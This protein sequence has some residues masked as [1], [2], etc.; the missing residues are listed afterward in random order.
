MRFVSYMWTIQ[1]RNPVQPLGTGA[2]HLNISACKMF[3]CYEQRTITLW[4]TR[5]DVR[6]SVHH[7]TI[8][9]NQPTRCDSFT[10]ILLDVCV[11]LNM[12]WAPPCP[13]SGAYTC[14]R[15]LCNYRQRVVVGVLL[16]VVSRV[17]RQITTNSAPTATLQVKPEAPSAVVRC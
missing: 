17:I 12:F 10:S 6:Q 3:I 4:N 14:T 11:W 2:V 9:I 5:F 8:Q 13:S 1:S 7:H 15:S 16:V